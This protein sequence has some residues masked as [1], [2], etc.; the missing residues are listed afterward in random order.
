MAT[1]TV[2]GGTG[3]M[4]SRTAD[5]LQARGHQVRLASRTTGVDAAT[6]QGLA[7]AFRGADVVLD[8][9]NLQTQSRA[10]AVP[11]FRSAA[12]N[13]CRE[14]GEAGVRHLVV[15]SI[16]NVADPAPRR[17]TGYYTGKAVQE[18][19]YA[20][21]PV[22][23]TLVRTT[24]W[25]TLARMFLEVLHAGPVRVV[26]SMRLQPVHPAA[27]AELLADVVEGE[28]PVER[29][30][31]ELAG[32]EVTTAGDMALR[33]ARADDL[34]GHVLPVAVPGAMR[35]AL[36]PGPHVRRDLRTFEDWLHD[37]ARRSA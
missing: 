15:L 4:G 28:P 36:L 5:L 17:F 19:V 2:V 3:E 27:A 23:T 13:V 33:L 29:R 32:P 14:A 6:G 20:H 9:L 21:A 8:C 34:P 1:V 30:L 18:A 16:V 24:A 35:T 37:S 31:V 22:P 26:P 10:R 12:T 11:F 7:E 25:F